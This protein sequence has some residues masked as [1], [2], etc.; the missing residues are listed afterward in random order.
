MNVFNIIKGESS[1]Y[2]ALFV[3]IVIL[4]WYHL[5]HHCDDVLLICQHC[6]Y[7]LKK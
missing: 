3:N 7:I 2:A 6:I 4:I 5:P 1:T